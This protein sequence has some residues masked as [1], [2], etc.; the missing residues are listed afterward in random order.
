MVQEQSAVNSVNELKVKWKKNVLFRT[1][2]LGNGLLRGTRKE[3]EHF[4]NE[5]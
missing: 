4:I 5:R 1:I 2:R 3:M